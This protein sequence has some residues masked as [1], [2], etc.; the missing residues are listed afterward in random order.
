M[1]SGPTT[2]LGKFPERGV[3]GGG[4]CAVR[5]RGMKEGAGDPDCISSTHL[6][7]IPSTSLPSAEDLQSCW[8]VFGRGSDVSSWKE[9]SGHLAARTTG[10]AVSPVSSGWDQGHGRR[11]RNRSGQIQDTCSRQSWWVCPR[12]QS[13]QLLK[14]RSQSGVPW[15]C[16]VP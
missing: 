2:N 14:P 5:E 1:K 16:P 13:T 4:W 12:S 15:G 11:V 7:F 9:R 3:G 10:E 6:D 8:R